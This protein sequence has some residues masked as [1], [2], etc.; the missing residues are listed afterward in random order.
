VLRYAHEHGCAWHS[1]T[2]YYAARGGSVEVL[3][4]TQEH[5]FPLDFNRCIAAALE[6]G[7]AEVVEYLR[8]AQLAA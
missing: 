6:R 4:Y 7:R 3:R 1:D 8:A 5:G 2:C